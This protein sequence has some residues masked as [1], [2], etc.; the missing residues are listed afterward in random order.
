VHIHLVDG[1]I[2]R[3]NTN[4]GKPFTWE[5]GPKDVYYVGENESV[6][7]RMQFDTG[8]SAGGRYMI[9]CH[10][11]SHED[12][13]MMIQFAVGDYRVNNPITSDVP[14][15]DTTPMGSYP[16]VYRPGLPAGIAGRYLMLYGHRLAPAALLV[17][18]LS[19]CTAGIA[20]PTSSPESITAVA[21]GADLGNGRPVVTFDGLMVRRRVA[22]AVQAD[23][24]PISRPC[25]PSSRVGRRMLA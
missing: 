6:T 19:G 22:L 25:A 20:T 12:H 24:T 13:D 2:I 15:A 23:E 16:P 5:K 10:N 18:I 21:P 11:L 14:V 4:G 1:Q 7:V 8:G 9:H 17:L 3:R